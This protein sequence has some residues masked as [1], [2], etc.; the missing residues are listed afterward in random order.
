MLVTIFIALAIKELMTPQQLSVDDIREQIKTS[1]DGEML[2]LVEKSNY[3][4]ASFKKGQSIFEVTVDDEHG[5]FSNLTLVQKLNEP[6]TVATDE[7]LNKSKN[8]T[9][10]EPD[11]EAVTEPPKETATDTP[12]EQKTETPKKPTPKPTAP[13]QPPTVITEQQAIKI[14][15]KEVAGEL[16]S[17]DFNQTTDG[18][19]Y[20]IEIE[21][22]DDEVLVL[23]HAITGEI[24]S[25]KYED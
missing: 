13:K 10:T 21:Q 24:L 17:I 23:V 16:D 2:S 14:A 9:V 22:N 6:P 7:T 15:L 3:Y 18:G 19:L 25:I 11:K 1:Y 4:I 5:Q 8:E 12:N 20:E